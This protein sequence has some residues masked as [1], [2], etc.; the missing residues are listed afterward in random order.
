[1]V[2]EIVTSKGK[3]LL[4]RM[5]L[6]LSFVGMIFLFDPSLTVKIFAPLVPYLYSL[7]GT[8]EGLGVKLDEVY[9]RSLLQ[10]AFA[11]ACI[12]YIYMYFKHSFK[13]DS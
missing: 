9:I 13:K 5:V 8:W 2:L 11:S 3:T 6:F 4:V 1:M 7:S 12:F 10:T